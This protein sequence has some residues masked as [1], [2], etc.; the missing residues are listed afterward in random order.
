MAVT[1]TKS[2]EFEEINNDLGKNGRITSWSQT[3]VG[4][5]LYAFGPSAQTMKDSLE[6]FLKTNP[7]GKVTKVTT[8]IE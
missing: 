4:T 1:T 7:M 2:F 6:N 3:K 5:S 8:Y